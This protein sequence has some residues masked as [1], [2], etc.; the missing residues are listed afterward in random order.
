MMRVA[1]VKVK[2]CKKCPFFRGD[3][4]YKDGREV[5]DGWCFHDEEV[6]ANGRPGGISP[7]FTN[8]I[9]GF[10]EWCLLERRAEDDP[11]L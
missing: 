8:I 7:V 1:H 9:D 3:V 5:I 11:S 2:S 6:S 4:Y 10:P